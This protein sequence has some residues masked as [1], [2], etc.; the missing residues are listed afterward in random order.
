[1]FIILS[2]TSKNLNS[3]TNFL[4]FVYKLNENKPLKKM[5]SIT[6]VQKILPSIVMSNLM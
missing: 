5:I 3:L 1:M 4:K 6:Q 2:I